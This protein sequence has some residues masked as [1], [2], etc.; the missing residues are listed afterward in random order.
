MISVCKLLIAAASATDQAEI[1]LSGV[2]VYSNKTTRVYSSLADTDFCLKI[3]TTVLCGAC[4]TS[5]VRTGSAPIVAAVERATS[6]SSTDTAE[7][8]PLVS[9]TFSLFKQFNIHNKCSHFEGSND[10][11]K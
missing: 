10:L 1:R 5:C 9:V 3:L 8:I 2:F 6:W 7:L 4:A 11:A